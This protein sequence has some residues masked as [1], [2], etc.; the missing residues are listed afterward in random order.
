MSARPIDSTPP[1]NDDFIAAE[2]VLG[3]LTPEEKHNVERRMESD[4]PFA[5]LVARW[6][7]Q[8]DGMNAE[9]EPVNPPADM[10]VLIDRRLFG[11]VSPQTTPFF[12]NLAFWRAFA[13][14]ALILAAIGFGR[15][16]LTSPS[17]PEK[18]LIASMEPVD[19]TYR[20]VAIY[21]QHSHHLKVSFVGGELPS[22]HSLE[23]W[24]IAGTDAPVSLGLIKSAQLTDFTVDRSH[25]G[26]LIE[27]AT[28]AI[29]LEPL[30]GSPNKAPTG[31]V[32][33]A[34]KV[35]EI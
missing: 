12:S 31:A 17:V 13:F 4:V 19:S 21:N 26:K 28:L 32:V 33:A 11:T 27:G 5:R 6:Q 2:Y 1:E 20:T 14:A 18:Q 16:L 9:F 15:D 24:L 7:H 30:G 25:A 10:K 8:F 22:D 34:G 29:S 35:R 23:L 3:V